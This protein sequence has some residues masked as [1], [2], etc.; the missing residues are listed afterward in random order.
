MSHV[1]EGPI[2]ITSQVI[3]EELNTFVGGVKICNDFRER[4]EMVGTAYEEIGEID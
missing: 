4:I 3:M 1:P 2:T